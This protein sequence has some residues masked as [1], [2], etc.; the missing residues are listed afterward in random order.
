MN[1]TLCC[2]RFPE[3]VNF[4]EETLSRYKRDETYC[5]IKGVCYN[6]KQLAMVKK[7]YKT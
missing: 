1:D 2:R 7:W 4:H 6:E 5:P 3:I